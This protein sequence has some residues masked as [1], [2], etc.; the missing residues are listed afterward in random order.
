MIQAGVAWAT[1]RRSLI[2]RLTTNQANRIM[3]PAPVIHSTWARGR[4]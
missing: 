1:C 2:Q 3:L 4:R